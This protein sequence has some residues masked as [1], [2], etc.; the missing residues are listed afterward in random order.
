MCCKDRLTADDFAFL[1]DSI[2]EF[3]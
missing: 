3:S 1:I 2:S